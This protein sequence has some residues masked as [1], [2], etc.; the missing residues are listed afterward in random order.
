MLKLIS[1]FR[2]HVA[3]FFAVLGP[4]FIT[5]VVDNDSGGIFTYSAAGAR[6]GYLPLWTLLPIT[7]V[8]II[9][10]EM[11][12]RMGAVTGKGLSDLIREEFGLRITFLL[13]GVLVL[14]NLTNVMAEFAGVAS[15]L[16]LFHISKYVSVPIAA[17]AVWL[18]VVKGNYQSVEKIFLFACVFYVTYVISGFLVKPDWKE[19][20][21]YSVKPVLLLEPAYIYMLIGMVGT[22]IAPWMQFYLQAAVVEKGIT[23]KAYKE[24]R[25]EVVVG[26]IMT[27][28]I[29]F[30]I[31]VACAGAI[32]TVRPRDIQDASE[33][34][35]GL[36]PF[37]EYAF[38]L[39]SAGLFNASIFAACIL[40]LSTA[41]SVCEGLGFEAGV[42]KRL[43]E[44]PIFYGLYTLLIVVG[45]G[46]ILMPKFPLVQMILL[47]QV[48]NG[49]LLPFVLIFMVLLINK[50]DLM[51]EWT[52]SRPANFVSW[53]TVAI[54]IGLT[55]ALVGITI[56]GMH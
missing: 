34:A 22:T 38:L 6:F 16:E 35:L 4:G 55:L 43:K 56:R 53:V 28:V 50:H 12:S 51:G 31:I 24:S 45:A 20:A 11:C 49:I 30:F 21:L 13:M 17:I 39:F 2:Y 26:C 47:S 52:N 33:A 46:V 54:M 32:Y 5:A 3:V 25:V 8:L 7:V 41:Y 15:S 19:A 9:T 44:A 18:L 40:P 29:A 27:S 23:A 10:Q 37:G 14:A 1:R 48:L 42:N 36:K